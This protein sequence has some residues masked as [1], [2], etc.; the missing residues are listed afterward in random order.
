MNDGILRAD[1]FR[2]FCWEAYEAI[3]YP[4]GDENAKGSSCMFT[5]GEYDRSGY[6]HFQ[7]Y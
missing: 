1:I 4:K 2:S 7:L 6:A 3:V 5:V